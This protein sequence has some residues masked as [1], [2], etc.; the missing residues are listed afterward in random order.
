MTPL[1][2]LS[3]LRRRRRTIEDQLTALGD[4][5]PGSLTPRYRKCGKPTC[6]CAAQGDPGHGPSWSLTWAV[7][8]KTRTRIIPAEAV[9]ET[10]AQIAEYRRARALTRELFEVSTSMC[11]AQLEAAK[12]ARKKIASRRWSGK[13]AASAP[14]NPTV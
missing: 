5:R 4:L 7:E 11:D 6:H 12:T 1:P 14:P 9:E 3:E 10:Q 8:G 13:S 2:D